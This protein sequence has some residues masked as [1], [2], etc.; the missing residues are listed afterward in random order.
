[1]YSLIGHFIGTIPM[2]KDSFTRSM[3]LDI[4]TCRFSINKQNKD[5]EILIQSWASPHVRFPQKCPASNKLNIHV[6]IKCVKLDFLLAPT[7]RSLTL[8][9][10]VNSYFKK[11]HNI[12]CSQQL[13]E[14]KKV[15]ADTSLTGAEYSCS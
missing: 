13:C 3:T 11:T 1:M 4:V 15:A 10:S 6:Y 5:Q 14:H 12:Y 9:F 7:L 2:L 8:K